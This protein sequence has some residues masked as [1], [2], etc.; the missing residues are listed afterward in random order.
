MIVS[1][2]QGRR[3]QAELGGGGFRTFTI[4]NRQTGS[5]H[6]R[7]PDGLH[8]VYVITL[9]ARVEQFVDRVEERHYLKKKKKR[10]KYSCLVT[11]V[12]STPEYRSFITFHCTFRVK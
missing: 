5:D 3:Q 10:E 1:M 2:L 9:D 4:S 7:I 8:L 12:I 6:V 11:R